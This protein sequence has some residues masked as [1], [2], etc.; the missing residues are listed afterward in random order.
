MAYCHRDTA[1]FTSVL[2]GGLIYLLPP[3]RLWLVRHPLPTLWIFV[4]LAPMVLDAGSHMLGNLLPGL[5]LRDSS[6]AVGTFNWWMRMLTGALVA[7]AVVLGVYPRFD[8][9]LRGVGR[10]L[11]PPLITDRL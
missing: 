5:M 9:D 8:R 6:D 3:L 11:D 4:L 1:L 10:D 2:I 7:L